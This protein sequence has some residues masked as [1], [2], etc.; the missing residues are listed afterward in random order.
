[1][2][3]QMTLE[4]RGRRA[5]GLGT[6]TPA[7]SKIHIYSSTCGLWYPGGSQSQLPMD[8]KG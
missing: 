8:T 4:L 3:I 7:Q 1:M 6:Q 2:Q 5:G